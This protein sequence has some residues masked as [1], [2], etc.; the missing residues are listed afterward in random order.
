MSQP[1][2]CPRVLPA[3]L[4]D[5]LLGSQQC[6]VELSP[7]GLKLPTLIAP[8]CSV[9]VR[10]DARVMGVLVSQVIQKNAQ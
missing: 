10:R 4:F 3:L 8:T 6:K 5:L 9:R 7:E 1:R 2:V